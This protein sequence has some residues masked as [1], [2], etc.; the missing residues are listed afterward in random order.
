M[1]NASL[2]C[3]A[4]MLGIYV[5]ALASTHRHVVETKRHIERYEDFRLHLLQIGEAEAAAA[6]MFQIKELERD[7]VYQEAAL[8]AVAAEVSHAFTNFTA[9]KADMSFS[10]FGN[11]GRKSV[12]YTRTVPIQ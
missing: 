7:L 11:M 6:V 1:G 9:D 2:Q 12:T 4:G 10:P 5:K 3:G 8:A